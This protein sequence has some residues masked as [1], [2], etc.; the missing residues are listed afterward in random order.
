MVYLLAWGMQQQCALFV[1]ADNSVGSVSP[2]HQR[3]LEQP[4]ASC[5]AHACHCLQ[6]STTCMELLALLSTLLIG[7]GQTQPHFCT[8]CFAP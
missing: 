8:T 4:T 6:L 5:A 1:G 7:M 3:E 2:S